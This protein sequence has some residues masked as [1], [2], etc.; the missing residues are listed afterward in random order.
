[1]QYID[2]RYH[3]VRRELAVRLLVEA[4]GGPVPAPRGPVLEVGTGARPM[5]D[6]LPADWLTIDADLSRRA[7][8]VHDRGRHPAVCFDATRPFP[9]TDRSLA[10]VLMGELVEHVYYP[11]E[12]LRE[13]H[14]V[15]SPGGILVLTTPNLATLQDRLF[16]L[17]GGAPRQVD[18]LHPHLFLH[19]RPF[20]VGL[21]RR[22]LDAV[23]F[24]I[25]AVRS[26]FVGV[27]L[28]SGRWLQSRQL[29]KLFPGLG[30][31]LVISA[32]RRRSP[33]VTPP[34]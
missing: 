7:L 19:I 5:L 15:L 3:A 9:F 1:M 24:D 30:G 31:S 18:P 16:F 22:L 2:D 17:A 21:L 4:L 11:E 25:V 14:R 34:G 10:A 13:V 28:G 32:R 12:M 27:C 33:A 23:G 6:D 8:Q 29:A 26:N 20:T